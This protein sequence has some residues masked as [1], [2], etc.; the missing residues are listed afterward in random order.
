MHV[1]RTYYVKLWAWNH[2]PS[3]GRAS[4]QGRHGFAVEAVDHE[5][6]KRKAT[7]L[8]VDAGLT[9]IYVISCDLADDSEDP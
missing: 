9:D 4:R 7:E 1:K 8:G 2:G 3:E 6:A 5:A